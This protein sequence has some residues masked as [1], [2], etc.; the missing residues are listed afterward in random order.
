MV[1]K[2]LGER[3]FDSLK[4]RLNCMNCARTLTTHQLVVESEGINE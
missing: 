3:N 2:E 1:E 4:S